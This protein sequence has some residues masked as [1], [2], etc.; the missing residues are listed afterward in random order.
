MNLDDLDAFEP[1]T[2]TLAGRR[3]LDAAADLFRDRGLTAT[4]VD[5]IVDRAGATK[6]T[7]YQRFGSKDR[8]IACY[9]QQRAHHWQRELLDALTETPSDE[10]LDVVYRCAASWATGRPRGCAFV[11]AWAE[12]GGEDGEAAEV[13]RAEKAWML[14]LFTHI[15]SG[16]P[17]TGSVLHLLYEGAQ[18]NAAIQNDPKY[19]DDACTA[20]KE[21]LARLR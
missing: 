2:T 11:N 4:G 18:V 16:D 21:L 14:S 13:I 6:R 20:S 7:L 10:A 3:I 19:F 12:V 8:L 15:A 1:V 9:L 17:T 5:S